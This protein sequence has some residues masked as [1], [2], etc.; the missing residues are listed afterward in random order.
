MDVF[1]KK[2]RSEVMSRIRSRDTKLEIL[3]RSRLFRD[4]F[5][6]RV[7]SGLLPGKPD[8]V[9]PKYRTVVFINGCFW[10]YHAS[11]KLAVMP[12]TRTSF[13]RKKLERNRLND[14]AKQ[15]RLRQIG[16]KP[17]VLWEC[18]LEKDLEREIDKVEKLL[19]A[20]D[21]HKKNRAK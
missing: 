13:W 10:H 18:R 7:N 1:T 11:C 19:K 15:R 3:V 5:R 12:K 20:P 2:K 8:I 6:F 21:G 17:I 4:G 14:R 9:L 16:W